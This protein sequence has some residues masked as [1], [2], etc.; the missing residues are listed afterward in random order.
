LTWHIAVAAAR[1][2]Q[3]ELES[4]LISPMTV[5]KRGTLTLGT[6]NVVIDFGQASVERSRSLAP[7]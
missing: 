7:Q 6:T 3:R 1:T 4:L 5:E 2:R